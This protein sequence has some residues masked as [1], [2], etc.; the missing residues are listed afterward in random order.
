MRLASLLL[1]ICCISCSKPEIPEF[2][3]VTDLQITEVQ[4]TN[5]GIS[6]NL[7]YFN[8]NSISGKLLHLDV[9][10]FINKI[11]ITIIN[12]DYDQTIEA[13]SAFKIPIETTFSLS[14]LLNHQSILGDILNIMT[15]KKFTIHYKGTAQMEIAKIPFP[16]PFDYEEE[17]ELEK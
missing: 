12:K 10:V 4:G 8:S 2:V 11:P 6:G 7:E 5:V 3:G 1:I 13:K 14:D 9:E 17:I 16:V 15:I